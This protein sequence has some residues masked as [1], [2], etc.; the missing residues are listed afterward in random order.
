MK[1]LARVVHDLVSGNGASR[2]SGLSQSEQMALL[3]MESLLRLSP[4]DL[5]NLLAQTQDTPE[6]LS[7]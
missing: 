2:R 7:K 6:W 3:E 5:S 4:K 1:E